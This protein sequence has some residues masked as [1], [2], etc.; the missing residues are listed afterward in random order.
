VTTSSQY[1][2]SD[3]CCTWEKQASPA[4]CQSSEHGVV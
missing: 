2:K 3:N 4:G 1:L